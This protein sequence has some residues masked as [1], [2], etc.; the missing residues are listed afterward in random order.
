MSSAKVLTLAKVHALYNTCAPQCPCLR[1]RRSAIEVV[2][3]KL[4]FVESILGFLASI[5]H[6]PGGECGAGHFLKSTVVNI[7]RRPLVVLLLL[8]ASSFLLRS[9]LT[10]FS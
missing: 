3:R 5:H 6:E 10:C 9:A 4:V 2:V 7:S 8:K 1:S